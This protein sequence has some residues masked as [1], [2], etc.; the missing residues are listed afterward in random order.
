MGALE[1]PCQLLITPGCGAP[2]LKNCNKKKCF[3]IEELPNCYKIKSIAKYQNTKNTVWPVKTGNN[4][5]YLFGKGCSK[6]GTRV[7]RAGSMPGCRNRRRTTPA[8]PY[9]QATCRGVPLPQRLW[10]SRCP[11]YLCAGLGAMLWGGKT[12]FLKN[13]KKTRGLERRT[14]KCAGSRQQKTHEKK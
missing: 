8:C 4:L 11:W 13:S 2:E 7:G 3:E 14:S 10:V 12:S 5:K 9:S 6:E 1:Q